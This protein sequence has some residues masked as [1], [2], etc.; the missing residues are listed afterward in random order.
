MT[1]ARS[2]LEDELERYSFSFPILK[3][4]SAHLSSSGTLQGRKIGWH[5]H[6]T[7]L[8]A[9]AAA[10]IVEN[11][12]RLYVSECNPST[13]DPGAV[14]FMKGL[15]IEVFQG[16][17][18]PSMVLKA[19]PEVLSDTGF[20]LISQ[21]LNELKEG[22]NYVCGACEITT[23]GIHKLRGISELAVPVININDGE[24]KSLIENY[25]G[26]GDGVI[27]ALFRLTGRLWSGRSAAVVGYGRVGA[28]VA[29]HLRRAGAVTYIVEQD[30]IRRLV[31]H[32]DGFGLMKLAEALRNCQL[33]VT[34]TGCKSVIGDQELSHAR[35]GLLLMNV[36][37]WSEEIDLAALRTRSL[38]FRPSAEHLDEYE[39][40]GEDG[41]SKR[42]YVLG[43]AGPANV[44]MLSGS[45]EP[46]LIHLS[47]EI[48]C[49][50]YLLKL[51]SESKRLVPGENPVSL[52]LQRQAS[53]L[54]LESLGLD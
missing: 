44:V 26:V 30:P 28:G 13:S 24:L 4:L 9:A 36:G 49:M 32:Y 46:T 54:A 40:I 27:E 19:Q 21:Y 11:G 43:G 34:A 41:L 39:I 16:S 52:D 37:H 53:L 35:D 23:S 12:A 33:I 29:E 8:T 20:V 42:I 51:A 3:K 31:A 6:L 2:G 5:C 47:T 1:D 22:R 50:E 25:H 38:S 15:G 45:P 14:A 17:D 18:S 48:L 10:V 7:G